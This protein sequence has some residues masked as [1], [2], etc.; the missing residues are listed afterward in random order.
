MCDEDRL[1]ARGSTK[2]LKL[3]KMITLKEDIFQ[4]QKAPSAKYYS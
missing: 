3:E 4:F 1:S 2:R